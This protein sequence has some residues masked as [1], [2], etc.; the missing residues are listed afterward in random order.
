MKWEH[1]IKI[2]VFVCTINDRGGIALPL[3]CQMGIAV[4]GIIIR[5]TSNFSIKKVS[6]IG[7]NANV[8]IFASDPIKMKV[9][10]VPC[11]LYCT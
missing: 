8:L 10:P 1:L 9:G 6:R 5:E 11:V 4:L 7:F 2:K 3:F